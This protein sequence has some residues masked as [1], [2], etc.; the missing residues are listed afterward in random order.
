MIGDDIYIKF[1][2]I[3]IK[4][5]PVA[6]NID[7]FEGLEEYLGVIRETCKELI[8]DGDYPNAQTLYSR[9]LASYKNMNKKMRDSLTEEQKKKREEALHLLNMN[10][11]LTCF[12]RNN[13][14]D[15]IKFAK[16]SLEFNKENPKAYYRYAMSLKGNGQL[17][18][19][20]EQLVMAI[21][22]Q[23]SDKNLRDEYKKI[24]D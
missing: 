7:T 4:R 6:T 8:E 16:E 12:K 15:A 20:K 11:S 23:P 10:L 21:K 13:F 5:N 17:E 14:K 2:I 22:L 3:G 19:A 1:S 9:V 24:T 18:E